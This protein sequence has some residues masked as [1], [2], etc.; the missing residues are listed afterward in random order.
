MVPP[1][2]LDIMEPERPIVDRV[3]LK[4]VR[5]HEFSGAGFVMTSKGVCRVG[6]ALA[7]HLF[8]VPVKTSKRSLLSIDGLRETRYA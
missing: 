5:E 6:A 1:Y 4:L 3:V 2:A 7:R 8:E